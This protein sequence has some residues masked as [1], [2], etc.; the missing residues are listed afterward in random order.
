ML[1]KALRFSGL[2]F[3]IIVLLFFGSAFFI[4]FLEVTGLKQPSPSRSATTTIPEPAK[5]VIQAKD[6]ASSQNATASS[7]QVA[8][9]QTDSFAKMSPKEHLEAAKAAIFPNFDPDRAKRHLSVIARGQK[10]YPVAQNLLKSVIAREKE[11]RKLHQKN[12]VE[13]SAKLLALQA[14]GYLKIIPIDSVVLIYVEP[15]F[16]AAALHRDKHNLCAYSWYLFHEDGSK[17]ATK[18]RIAVR[19]EDMTSHELLATANL[20]TGE[21]EIVK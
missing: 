12:G 13:A 6:M 1:K 7:A 19:F 17:G 16:W 8:A 5:P 9:Q 14:K 20:E 15:K 11:I 2:G 4:A 18:P 21:I 10:E 3:L